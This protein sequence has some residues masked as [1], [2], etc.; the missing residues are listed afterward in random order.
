MALKIIRNW[1]GL[2]LEYWMILNRTYV[3]A[4][5]QTQCM[6]VVYPSQEIRNLDITNFIPELNKFFSFYGDLTTEQLY[7][8]IKKNEEFKNSE[9]V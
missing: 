3:K 9:D 6:L 2:N 5:N 4:T 8:E 7:N 1:K